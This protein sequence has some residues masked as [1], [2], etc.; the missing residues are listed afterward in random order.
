MK[1]KLPNAPWMAVSLSRTLWTSWIN[2]SDVMKPVMRASVALLQ[3]Q[4][5]TMGVLIQGPGQQAVRNRHHG[6]PAV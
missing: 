6:L 3:R 4:S 5:C 2:Q 1:I